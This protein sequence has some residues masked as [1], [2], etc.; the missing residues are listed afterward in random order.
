MFL[1]AKAGTG[2]RE[3]YLALGAQDVLFKPFDPMALPDTLASVWNQY[4]T[5]PH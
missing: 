5:T 2:V 3:S 4:S 1:T